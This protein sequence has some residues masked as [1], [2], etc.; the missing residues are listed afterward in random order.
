MGWDRVINWSELKGN[1]K[2]QI[3]RL[4]VDGS[5]LIR[6][7]QMSRDSEAN[8]I[9]RVN[10]VKADKQLF[11]LHNLLKSISSFNNVQSDSRQNHAIGANNEAIAHIDK[12]KNQL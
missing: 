12:S 9:H 4:H 3:Q 2:R 11:D 5:G 7:K 1:A 10:K 8:E 6:G